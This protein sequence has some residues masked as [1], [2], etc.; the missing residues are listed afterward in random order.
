MID[1]RNIIELIGKNRGKYHSCLLTCYSF[2]FSFFE[3]RLLPELRIANI[4]NVNILA[5]G[6]F[7]ELAQENTTGKEFKHNKTYNFIPVYEEGVFHP[8]IMLLSGLK[9]GLLIIG[10]GNVTSSG[11]SAND[12]IWGAFHLDNLENENAPL[13]AQVWDYLKQYT[14][15]SKGFVNQQIG[16]ISQ[17]SPWLNEIKILRGE[18]KFESI[19]QSLY[20]IS[21]NNKFSIFEQLFRIV[22]KEELDE[23]TIISP[24]FDKE[25][26]VL[27]QFLECYNPKTFTCLVDLNSGLLPIDLDTNLKNRISF[28]DWSACKDDYVKDFNR[29][30]AKVV[31]FKFKDGTEYM[32]LGSANVTFSA[33][34]SLG[35]KGQNAEAGILLKRNTSPLHSWIKELRIKIPRDTIQLTNFNTTK[36]INTCSIP[37]TWFKQRIIYSELSGNEITIYINKESNLTFKISIFS[38]QDVLIETLDAVFKGNEVSIRCKY[39]D[40]VFKISFIDDDNNRVSNFSIVHRVEFLLKCNPDPNQQ[41][42]DALLEEDYLEGDGVTT[43]LQYLDYNWADDEVENTINTIV[44]SGNFSQKKQNFT[45]KSEDYRKLGSE[46]FN[47]VSYDVVLR[48]SGEL[49]NSNVKIAEF[50]RLISSSNKNKEFGAKESTEQLLLEDSE[51][52][53]D[54]IEIE[55]S[56]KSKKHGIKE[57]RSISTYFRKLENIYNLKLSIFYESKALTLSPSDPITIKVLSNILIAFELIQIY[58]GKKFNHQVSPSDESSIKEELYL[59]NGS[60]YPE[61]NSIKSFLVNVFGKFLL[62]A[63]A[64]VKNYDYEIINQKFESKRKLLLIKSIGVILNLSWKANEEKY[65]ET[66]LLNCLYFISPKE[67]IDDLSCNELIDKLALDRVAK[68][69]LEFFANGVLLRYKL[70]LNQFNDMEQRRKNLIIDINDLS[71]GSI[72]FNSKIGFNRISKIE[73]TTSPNVKLTREGFLL[74]DTGYILDKVLIGNKIVQFSLGER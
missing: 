69:N 74:K 70:W 32:M 65:K 1:R 43:L 47:K 72:I 5:D 31:H 53:G 46:D 57:K 29:L 44:H 52:K 8:K 39:P 7:L 13:F 3:E 34:G 12:E 22:P 21:N 24:Y 25:G 67:I 45:E 37:R 28:Y 11:L 58:Q 26:K 51:Q 38:R 61:P 33:M 14:K 63:T 59:I 9:H 41:K 68:V 4:K 73:Y 6:H 56:I 42:L 64:G 50:L 18:I 2:D 10:S 40:D 66:L 49:S 36:G 27:K 30:H 19:N 23:L 62:L 17:Y 20:F 48:Q 54:G 71:I 55:T 16:W 15:R 35:S 60:I